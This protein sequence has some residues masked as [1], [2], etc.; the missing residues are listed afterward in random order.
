MPI[1]PI[2]TTTSGMSARGE[3]HAGA[4]VRRERVPRGAPPPEG[5]ALQEIVWVREIV[6]AHTIGARRGFGFSHGARGGHGGARIGRVSPGW[7]SSAPVHSKATRSIGARMRADGDCVGGMAAANGFLQVPSV[8]SVFSVRGM[9]PAPPVRGGGITHTI[10]CSAEKDTA[11]TGVA[12]AWVSRWS[13]VSRRCCR[14]DRRGRGRGV[15]RSRSGSRSR[16]ASA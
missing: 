11:A 3:C 1:G 5:A 6:C 13:G 8:F 12:A 2:S 4:T 14:A 10:S 15:P 9:E 7:T 16:A